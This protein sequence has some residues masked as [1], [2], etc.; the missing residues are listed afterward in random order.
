MKTSVYLEPHQK[1]GLDQAALLTG[2]SQATLIRDAIDQILVQHVAVRPAMK[3]RA[4]GA[5]V[6][7]RVDELMVDFG[8]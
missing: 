3:A 8:R 6:L 2:R 4:T 1:A 5:T 7:D